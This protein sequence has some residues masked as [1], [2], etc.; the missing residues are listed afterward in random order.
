MDSLRRTAQSTWE[1][2]WIELFAEDEFLIK[3]VGTVAV[4]LLCFLLANFIFLLI[5]LTGRPQWI[6]KYKIQEDR[7]FPVILF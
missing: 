1:S 5:D 6:Y 7:N 3:T 4:G 2:I